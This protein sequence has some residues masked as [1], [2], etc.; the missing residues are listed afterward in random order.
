MM[1]TSYVGIAWRLIVAAAMCALGFACAEAHEI[2]PALLQITERGDHRYDVLWK[3]PTVGPLAIHLVPHISGGVLEGAPASLEITPSFHIRLW[4]GIDLGEHGLDGRTLRIDGLDRTMTSVLVSITPASGRPVQQVL[5]S[6][7]TELSFHG[8]RRDRAAWSSVMLGIEHILTGLDHL[9]FVLCLMLMVR[10]IKTLIATITAF[11]VAHSVT[12]AA[13]TLGVLVVHP[14]TVEALVSLSVL[15]VAAEVTRSFRGMSSLCIR[16]P[17]GMAFLFGLLH[18]FAF[19]GALSEIGLPAGA[20]LSS[21]FLFN[22]G[23]ELGQ[24]LFIAAILSIGRILSRLPRQQLDR[25]RWIPPYAVGSLATFWVIER[26]ILA[27][28]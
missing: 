13:T 22:V 27:T 17:S 6:Q 7:E 16:Y 2:R 24:L 11:T 28:G 9:A 21:L 3:Q 23:V 10:S 14:P 1:P 19:A 15:F 5:S 8:L 12:L 26:M 20:I 4:K 25:A 18:G